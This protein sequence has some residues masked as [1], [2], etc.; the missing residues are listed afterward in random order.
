[1][2]GLAN[3]KNMFL[4]RPTS[5]GGWPEGEYDPPVND[6]IYDYLRSMG[7]MNERLLRAYVRN[8]LIESDAAKEAMITPEEPSFWREVGKTISRNYDSLPKVNKDEIDAWAE[9][10]DDAAGKLGIVLAG[11]GLGAAAFSTGV[12]EVLLA[13]SAITG[14]LNSSF[15]GTLEMQKG[16]YS[17]AGGHVANI[18]MDMALGA[19]AESLAKKAGQYA[20]DAAGESVEQAK[21]ISRA[22]NYGLGPG[23]TIPYGKEA[24]RIFLRSQGSVAG[25]R[26]GWNALTAFGAGLIGGV[27][28]EALGNEMIEIGQSFDE[29]R[30]AS[31]LAPRP[32]L[33]RETIERGRRFATGTQT[34]DDMMRLGDSMQRLQFVD[35]SERENLKVVLEPGYMEKLEAEYLDK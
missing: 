26:S 7:L 9:W 29:A 11:I 13:A 4:D 17:A 34:R 15:Q 25:A 18:A 5:H 24:R 2:Y 21:R 14:I 22:R 3:R 35:P 31:G 30:R 6:R 12:G 20:G 8:I 28:L 32:E 33:S 23:Q 27:T 19:G 10:L 16:N 1:M